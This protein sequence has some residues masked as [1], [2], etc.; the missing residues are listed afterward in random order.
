MTAGTSADLAALSEGPQSG[1]EA[2]L[3]ARDIT[4]PPTDPTIDRS[5]NCSWELFP[6]STFGH[7]S[8]GFDSGIPDFVILISSN[9]TTDQTLKIAPIFFASIEFAMRIVS[10]KSTIAQTPSALAI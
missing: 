8:F 4:R 7:S 3:R 2:V 9:K 5:L 10:V 6:V 1:D